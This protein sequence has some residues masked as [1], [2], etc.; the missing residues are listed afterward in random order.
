MTTRDDELFWT[1]LRE[2]LRDEDME[3]FTKLTERYPEEPVL[4][5]FC[6]VFP[7][8]RGA[9]R[10]PFSGGDDDEMPGVR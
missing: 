9:D 10:L 8:L 3:E 5:L 2:T 4:D 1:R 6:R 7:E